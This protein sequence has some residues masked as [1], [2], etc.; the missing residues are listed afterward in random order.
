MKMPSTF[1][2]ISKSFSICCRARGK[3]QQD[4]RHLAILVSQV[5]CR[6]RARGTRALAAIMAVEDPA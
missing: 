3:A 2:T 6:G 4:A 1:E 5:G